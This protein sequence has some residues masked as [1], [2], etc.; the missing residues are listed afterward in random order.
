MV[1]FK[2][3]KG[4][5][6]LLAYALLM[7]LAITLSILVYNWLRFY[8]LPSETKACPEGVNIIL[9]EYS[10][11]DGKINL[12]LRNKGLFNIDGYIVKVNNETAASTGKP[13]GLPVY[14]LGSVSLSSPLSPG[15]MTSKEWPYKDAY[16]RIVEVE[17]EPFRSEGGKTIYCDKAVVMQ[18]IRSVDCL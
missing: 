14:L 11:S 7:G 1:K 13:K 8:I 15:M 18:P 17:I 3:K 2:G 4:I 9:Q 6:E 16:T 5:A 10:C 12:T